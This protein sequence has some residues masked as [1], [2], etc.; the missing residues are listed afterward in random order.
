MFLGFRLNH[1]LNVYRC[2]WGSGALY[3]AEVFPNSKITAFSNSKTQ[4]Q[5]IDAKAEEKGFNNLQVSSFLLVMS[6][7]QASLL[8]NRDSVSRE[9]RF[10]YFMVLMRLLEH[11]VIL[12]VIK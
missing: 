7:S 6:I 2:G 4:K 5:Y 3:F 8:C 10:S 9:C 12:Y 11:R 1:A